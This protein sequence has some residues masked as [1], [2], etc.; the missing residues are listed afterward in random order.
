MADKKPTVK[1]DLPQDEA[2]ILMQVKSE[3]T[4]SRDFMRSRRVIL[5]IRHKLYNNQRKQRDKVGDTLI[6]NIINTQLA[7]YYTD[8]MTVGFHQRDMGD[9]QKAQNIENLA[10]FDYDEM[11][12]D[13][14]DYFV[15]WDRQFYGVGIR[16]LTE[17]DKNTSTPQPRHHDAMSWLPDPAGSVIAKNFR[18]SGFEVE[19][20]R[21]DISDENG[22][23]N[24]EQLKVRDSARASEKQ[25][26]RD[27]KNEAAGLDP[28]ASLNVDAALDQGEGTGG[29]F[30]ER[31]YD[32]FD[33]VDQFTQLKGDDGITRKYLVTVSDNLESLHRCEEIQ[34]VTPAEKK[35]ISRVP[36]PFSLNY[37]SPKPGDPLGV[38]VPDLCEDKQRARSV[39]MNLRKKAEQAKLYPMYIYNRQKILNR[40]DL[41]FA[42]NKFI[43]VA[44]DVGSN[45]I[46]PINKAHEHQSDILVAEQELEK[47][48]QKAT[49]TDNVSQGV[50]PDRQQ[51]LGVEQMVQA[52]AS[53]KYILGAK[54]NAWGDK[55]F[56]RLWYRMYQQNFT[57]AG[58][59]TIRI[60]SAFGNRLISLNPKDIQTIKDPDITVKSK[61]ELQQQRQREFLQWQTI[62]PMIINDPTKPLASK[63]YAERRMARLQ[64]VPQEEIAVIFPETP[65]EVR[66]HMENELLSRNEPVPVDVQNE[67]HL[68]HMVINSQAD[69]SDAKAAHMSKHREAYIMSGQKDQV[70]ALEEQRM[71]RGG[72][73]TEAQAQNQVANQSSNQAAA[74]PPSGVQAVVK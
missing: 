29:E 4:K 15:Q 16:V 1:D 17:W 37:Y 19:Y 26:D 33:M 25:A 69:E 50:Q 20:T 54:F 6:Y 73:G 41:D 68:S 59:K 18:W 11:D 32:I 55:R 70:K 39:F 43:G 47:Q 2:D 22:F 49:G 38:S 67:D 74:T 65:D 27:A 58:A 45:V 35:D 42:F 23:F 60:Q 13:V 52:N 21:D 14:I 8:E 51:T 34:P 9:V 72:G 71:V 57:K 56:W 53:L 61:L 63:R 31:G 28:P 12:M 62:V 3:I 36:F 48:A 66:A 5:R 24:Q 7:I 64:N 46:E 10:R 40:R 44:G 30:A